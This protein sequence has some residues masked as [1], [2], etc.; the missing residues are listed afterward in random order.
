A[1][2]RG[3]VEDAHRGAVLPGGCGGSTRWL[4][5]AG[6]ARG[7]FGGST[8]PFP[9]GN[10]GWLPG[11]STRWLPGKAR[12]LSCHDA[13]GRRG[14]RPGDGR[15]ALRGPGRQGGVWGEARGRFGGETRGG[16]RGEAR[17]G[18]RGKHGA[19]VVTKRVGFGACALVMGARRAQQ[20]RRREPIPEMPSCS[21]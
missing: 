16:F 2:E 20:P 11:R 9:G 12:G 17:G 4:S 15:G 1:G 5:G 10:T 13:R 19:S 8:G 18:F 6:E 7:G 14:M 3:S 21:G